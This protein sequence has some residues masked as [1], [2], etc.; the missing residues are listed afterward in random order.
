MEQHRCCEKVEKIMSTL[1][2]VYDMKINETSLR[3]R[4][5]YKNS[6]PRYCEEALA[7]VRRDLYVRPV[8]REGQE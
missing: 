2:L 6:V 5:S 4:Y 3:M 1:V 7:I 8:N